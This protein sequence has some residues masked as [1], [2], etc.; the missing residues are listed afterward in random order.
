M[1]N[2]EAKT[3]L[4]AAFPA[5]TWRLA[6]NEWWANVYGEV[7]K[8]NIAV[9]PPDEGVGRETWECSLR[10]CGVTVGLRDGETLPELVRRAS[11]VLTVNDWH[12]TRA[13]VVGGSEVA[14]LFDTPDGD[15]DGFMSRREL[16]EI[17]AGRMP[18]RK[19]P[20]PTRWGTRLEDVIIEAV[21]EELKL[22][23]YA[24]RDVDVDAL[25]LPHGVTRVA[26]DRGVML[27]HESGLGGNPD[28]V[29][30]TPDGIEGLEI[31]NVSG[32]A[33]RTMWP[34]GGETLK[35]GIEM[36]NRAYQALTGFAR[37]HTVAL[38]DGRELK[39]WT[40]DYDPAVTAGLFEETRRFW[41]SIAANDPPP[42]C[43]PRDNDAIGRA[44]NAMNAGTT[45]KRDGD[46][47]FVS[48]AAA[49]ADA[50]TRRLEAEKREEAEEARLRLAIGEAETITADGWTVTAKRA[51][52]T[53]GTIITLDMVGQ[54]IN[55]RKGS[56]RL[57]VK[58]PKEL[59]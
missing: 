35:P 14:A 45:E 8:T 48:A 13:R 40:V 39:P 51:K 58:P 1:T 50:R 36:Q 37:W 33:L 47:A 20:A 29:I 44:W 49:F 30:I 32:M 19:L 7:G 59:S 5:I 23:A 52:D 57:L 38:V 22:D 11:I 55:A 24:W 18:P 12:A 53:A 6:G 2:T 17:K 46:E 56:R 21:R 4:S 43:I 15:G 34:N 3:I 16:W 28:G 31:K 42:W 25:P 9:C 10:P 27:I 26:T 54:T 41:A